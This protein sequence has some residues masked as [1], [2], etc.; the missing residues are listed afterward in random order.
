MNDNNGRPSAVADHLSETE[1]WSLLAKA[2]IGRLGVA[3]LGTVEIFPVNFVVDKMRIVFRTSPGHKLFVLTLRNSVA[4]EI[5]GWDDRSA[6]SVLVK[7]V[8]EPLQSDFEIREASKTGLESWAP[9]PKNTYVQIRPS[10]VTGR[11]FERA[12]IA[13]TI[14][15]W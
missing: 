9:D 13:E 10:E 14:W 1:C 3:V 11:R 12:P 6:W 2:E 5:D 7:G 4:F 15:Y 8:A